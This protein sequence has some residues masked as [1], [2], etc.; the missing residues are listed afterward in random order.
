MGNNKIIVDFTRVKNV[1]IA[2]IVNIPRALI[3]TGLI[4]AEESYEIRSVNYA[5]ITSKTLYLTGKSDDVIHAMSY[6]YGTDEEAQKALDKFSE[7]IR[8]YNKAHNSDNDYN[9]YVVRRRAE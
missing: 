9:E 6:D 4:I 3:G 7:L 2:E 1:L 8:E 5:M